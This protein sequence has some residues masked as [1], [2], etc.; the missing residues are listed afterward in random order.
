MQRLVVNVALLL[1]SA[2]VPAGAQDLSLAFS[3][4][5]QKGETPRWAR[6]AFFDVGRVTSESQVGKAA[7]ATLAA[8]RDKRS[9]EADQKAKALRAEQQKLEAAGSV[10]SDRARAELLKTIDRFQLDL[11]RF[12][13]DARADVEAAQ[14]DLEEQFRRKLAPAVER[15]AAQ[16]GIDMVF[17][18]GESGL[19]WA[20]AKF[21][22]SVDIVKQLDAD[23]QPN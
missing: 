11:Q 5:A 9:A 16:R 12:L 10:L 23:V 20:D 17:T 19:F 6:V 8:L 13:E 1:V 21:D 3:G 18:R 22:L 4:T 14:R 2:A 7:L 15:V